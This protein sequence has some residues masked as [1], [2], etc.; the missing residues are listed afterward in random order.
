MNDQTIATS[1]P[2]QRAGG[3]PRLAMINS[4]AGFG[5]IST[6]IALPVIS[7][8]QVH[9][10]PVPTSVLSNHLAFPVCHRTDYTCQMP[11]YLNAWEQLG[12]TFDGLYC[13]FLGSV[14]QI[15]IVKDFVE[16]PMLQASGQPSVF[17]L[18]PVMGDNGRTFSTITSQHCLHMKELASLADLLT[19]N[20]TE[21]C[22]L[23]DTP[24]KEGNWSLSQLEEICRKLSAL[25]QSAYTAQSTPCSN[26]MNIVITGLE[27]GNQIMNY[28]WENGIG[29]TYCVEKAGPSRNGTGDLFASILA[30]DAMHGVPLTESVRKAADFVALCIKGSHEAGIPIK[31]GVIFE[32]YLSL[33]CR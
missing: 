22:I 29:S 12:L 30:A 4:F 9:V 28:I 33:L 3:I 25:K 5:H 8:M 23:T 6:T 21:A 19:P 32:K 31:E 1:N 2:I 7:V 24:Y 14:D 15:A 17:L 10:C 26:K 13:G 20:I 27:D 11:G 16:G 18:D